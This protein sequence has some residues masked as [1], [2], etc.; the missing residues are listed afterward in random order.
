[1]PADGKPLCPLDQ[2]SLRL[3]VQRAIL[4][5]PSTPWATQ[6]SLWGHGGCVYRAGAIYRSREGNSVF[7]LPIGNQWSEREDALEMQPH[8]VEWRSSARLGASLET[9]KMSS[10]RCHMPRRSAGVI[11]FPPG[12]RP[13]SPSG[14]T[15]FLGHPQI[16][17]SA[18]CDGAQG[19]RRSYR[20]SFIK[21]STS[22]T[23]RIL[24]FAM[25]ESSA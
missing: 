1:V 2:E 23:L 9:P 25:P 6:C 14:S 13:D 19:P 12:D 15:D 10:G 4:A 3:Q 11:P 20:T 24:K 22:L 8:L 5:A 18:R 17:L 16:Q 7:L 21:E